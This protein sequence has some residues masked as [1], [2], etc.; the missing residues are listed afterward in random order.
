VQRILLV[1]DEPDILE[2]LKPILERA[3]EG[4]EV[5]T[6]L[7]GPEA[8]TLLRA[9]PVDLIISDYKMPGM[10]GLDFLEEARKLAPSVPRIIITAFPDLDIALRAINETG[11][12]NFITK[13]FETPLLIEHVRAALFKRR[14]DAL[15]TQSV[16]KA[17]GKQAIG[18][19]PGPTA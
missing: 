13:P 6:A 15:W 16:N 14:V 12:E 18:K 2:S 5:R 4:V 17:I 8:L 11:I 3:I 9:T 10:S 19:P 7:S 1:D